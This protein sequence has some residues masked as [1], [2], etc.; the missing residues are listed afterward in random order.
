LVRQVNFADHHHLTMAGELQEFFKISFIKH[1][2]M[3]EQILKKS[4][5]A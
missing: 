4:A 2:E 3:L 5:S 1:V